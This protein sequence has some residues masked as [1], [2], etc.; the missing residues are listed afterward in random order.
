MPPKKVQTGR[1]VTKKIE[2]ES[3]KSM[4]D[5][6]FTDYSS[7][8]STYNKKDYGRQKMKK[9]S[10]VSSEESPVSSLSDVSD[11]SEGDSKNTSDGQNDSYTK[12]ENNS[13]T[14]DK[15]DD[16]I[17]EVGEIDEIEDNDELNSNDEITKND[18]DENENENENEALSLSGLRVLYADDDPLNR[19]VVQTLLDG[20]GVYLELVEDGQQAVSRVLAPAAQ[21]DLVLMDLQMPRL[22]G[23]AATK[24]IRAQRSAEALPIVGLSAHALPAHRARAADAGM[25]GFLTKPVM[26]DELIR[27]IRRQLT[28]GAEARDANQVVAPASS[29]NPLAT[30]VELETLSKQL[31]GNARIMAEIL[32]LLINQTP[33]LIEQIAEAIAQSDQA[34]V[35]K[36]AHLLKGRAATVIAVT[37]SGLCAELDNAARQGQ[38]ERFEPLL[39]KIQ[40]EYRAVAAKATDWLEANRD[41]GRTP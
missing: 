17:D 38:R 26:R 35:Q 20:T 23:L 2:S 34:L 24:L 6:S 18:D 31:R 25:S 12:E 30:A 13:F 11:S 36:R 22:D 15:D 19:T 28:I 1:K 39:E 9:L 37:L 33:A 8:G 21:F 41:P 5:G 4:T 16:E 40:A 27:V 32:S 3:E 29:D 10:R 14:K 7:D